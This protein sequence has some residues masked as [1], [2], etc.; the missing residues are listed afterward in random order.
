MGSTE[1][2]LL[3]NR[4]RNTIENARYTKEL[5]TF[6]ETGPWLLVTSAFHMPRAFEIFSD[7]QIDVMPYPTDFRS[8]HSDSGFRWNLSRGAS[9]LKILMHEWIGIIVYRLTQKP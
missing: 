4:S 1:R 3:E 5:T 2:I 7:H 9:Q 6:A 8:N